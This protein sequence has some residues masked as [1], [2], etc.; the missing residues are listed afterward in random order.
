MNK[1]RKTDREKVT[2]RKRQQ[3]MNK[4]RKTDRQKVTQR[5]R[6]QRKET[7][8]K[9]DREKVTQTKRQQRMNKRAKDR[10]KAT[11]T[12]RQ[13]RMNT[14]RQTERHPLIVAAIG[15]CHLPAVPLSPFPRLAKRAPL[16]PVDKHQGQRR[17]AG[18]D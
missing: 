3:R 16:S 4:E 6:Q 2:H 12:K 18:R 10:E 17:A 5:E 15:P 14:D 11:Q 1:D 8:R 13:K 9:T 7:N